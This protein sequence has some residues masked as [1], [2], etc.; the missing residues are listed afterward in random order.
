MH[1]SPLEN[2]ALLE[3]MKGD[4][5]VDEIDLYL[6][7]LA[8]IVHELGGD[9]VDKRAVQGKF[10]EK[11]NVTTPL[12]AIDSLLVRAKKRDLLFKENCQYFVNKKSLEKVLSAFSSKEAEIKRSINVVI[13]EY[14][15]FCMSEFEKKLHRNEAEQEIYDFIRRNI[16][17]F[18]EHDT[19]SGLPEKKRNK[20]NYMV[21]SFIKFI[22]SKKKGVIPDIMCIIRGTL[23]ANYLTIVDKTVSKDRFDNI[24]IYLDTPIVIG[25]LGWDGPTKQKSLNEF[26]E[27]LKELKVTI[28][29]FEITY[30]ELSGVFS[31]WINSLERKNYFSLHE[32]TR[33]LFKSKGVTP[34]QLRH[35][36]ALLESNLMKLS[37]KVDKTFTMKPEFCCDVKRLDSLLKRIGFKRKTREHDVDCISKVFSS[38]ENRSITRLNESFSVFITSNKTIEDVAKKILSKGTDEHSIQVVVSESWLATLL[39]LKHPEQFQSF[40][41]DVLLTNAYS[42]LNAN[43][44]FWR[45]FLARLERL[46]DGGGVGE[47]DFLIVRDNSALFSLAK[48]NAVMKD[49]DL[50][51]EDVYA[52]VEEIKQKSNDKLNEVTTENEHL[53][54]NVK[55]LADKASRLIYYGY[56]ILAFVVGSAAFYSY[57]PE[58]SQDENTSFNI[59][60]LFL[61]IT[62]FITFLLAYLSTG[63]LIKRKACPKVYKYVVK[64][65]TG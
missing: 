36:Q 24:T 60:N 64:K 12:S 38:R 19:V 61:W 52:I 39:W 21:A 6:P 25:M 56:F 8:N 65:M 22:N 42:T 15:S 35:E 59:L 20:N 46:K 51:D 49:E 55:W 57:G 5:Q 16:S 10:K 62:V 26:L 27:L 54:G 50:N 32:M 45:N 40:P 4:K 28:K 1:N 2:L 63:K 9:I 3:S 11:F 29:I 47:E 48:H 41:F 34:E 23:L 17:I 18:S 33:Q 13:D 31:Y 14:L 53:V 37:I 30:S 43:D 58:L 44:D 7:F